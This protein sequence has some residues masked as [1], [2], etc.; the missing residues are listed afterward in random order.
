MQNKFLF[1]M[2]ELNLWWGEEEEEEKE[3]NR[4]FVVEREAS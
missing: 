1:C 4:L 3:K 2:P